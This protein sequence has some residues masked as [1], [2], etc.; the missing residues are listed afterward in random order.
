MVINKSISVNTNILSLTAAPAI[1]QLQWA[2]LEVFFG[3]G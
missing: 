1:G 2:Y 3:E